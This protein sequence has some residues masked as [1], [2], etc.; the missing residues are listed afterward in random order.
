MT[1]AGGL[2]LQRKSI[3]YALQIALGL[4]AA[5]DKGI[6]HCDIKPDNVFTSSE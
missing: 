5:H 2:L 3:D 1:I 4:A 6:V